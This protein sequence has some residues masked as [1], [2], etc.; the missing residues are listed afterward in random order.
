MAPVRRPRQ[1]G[2]WVGCPLPCPHLASQ[3]DSQWPRE[4]GPGQATGP[5]NG[6]AHTNQT[7]MAWWSPHGPAQAPLL[8]FQAMEWDEPPASEV[9]GL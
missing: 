7:L 8:W 5:L 3:P 1:A 9:P 4:Q 6:P 2:W